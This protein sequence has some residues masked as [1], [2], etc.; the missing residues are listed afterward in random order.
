V[1]QLAAGIAH[2]INNPTSWVRAN[3]NQ[4]RSTWER[5]PKWLPARGSDADLDR[6][7]DE[8]RELIDE[9]VE[10]IEHT[11]AVVR[12]VRGFAQ[13][14]SGVREP[15][16]LNVIVRDVL[17][18]AQPHLSGRISVTLALGDVPPV[19]G[20]PQELRQ[21]LLHLMMNARQ[22]ISSEGSIQI[23]TRR[24][25]D[26]ACVEVADDG[27]GIAP[28]DLDRIFDPFFT[29]RPEG[30]GTGLGLAISYEIARAHGGE[31][32]AESSAGRGARLTLRIPLA[33]APP[34]PKDAA[35]PTRY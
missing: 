3:L 5:L 34:A 16:D 21:V 13:R 31:L 2:E 8:G 10:G 20:S 18:I 11:A 9:S 26:W 15:V 6:V 32:R 7:L 24:A 29:T 27:C 33:A 23:S 1:G 25:G 30:E 12:A 35:D 19:P 14:G 28:E 22:A 4:L 17:R